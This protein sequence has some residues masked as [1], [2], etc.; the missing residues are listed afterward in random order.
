MWGLGAKIVLYKTV[1]YLGRAPG[2]GQWMRWRKQFD[3]AVH[4]RRCI[5]PHLMPSLILEF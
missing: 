1:G 4:G 3:M 5:S 2:G